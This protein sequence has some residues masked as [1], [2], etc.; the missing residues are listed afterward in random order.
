MLGTGKI[1]FQRCRTA[2]VSP[3]RRAAPCP[4]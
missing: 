1:I 4:L 2:A 3:R